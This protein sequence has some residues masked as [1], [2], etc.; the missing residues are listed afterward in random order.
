LSVGDYPRD[1]QLDLSKTA[2]LAVVANAMMNH[3]EFYTLR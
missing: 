3:D 1:Q 2:A